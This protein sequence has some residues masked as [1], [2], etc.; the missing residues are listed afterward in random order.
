MG[1]AAQNVCLQAVAAGLGTVVVG[2]FEDRAL[3]TALQMARGEE[4]LG[5]GCVGRPRSGGA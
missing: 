1:H 4:P 2:A 3:R 5:L